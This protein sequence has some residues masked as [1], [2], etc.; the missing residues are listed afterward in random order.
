V[1]IESSIFIHVT[2]VYQSTVMHAH[3][4]SNGETCDGQVLSLNSSAVLVLFWG[5]PLE[6]ARWFPVGE[7]ARRM[8]PPKRHAASLRRTL[9]CRSDM[10]VSVATSSSL[11]GDLCS[12]HIEEFCSEGW[13]RHIRTQHLREFR[14]R[15]PD[16]VEESGG[17]SSVP[18]VIAQS[19]GTEL[20]VCPNP[21]VLIWPAGKATF[22]TCSAAITRLASSR[23]ELSSKQGATSM[24]ALKEAQLAVLQAEVAN[25][26]GECPSPEQFLW[27]PDDE[28]WP[29]C[30]RWI[31]RKCGRGSSCD[32]PKL[33]PWSA[34][35]A[36]RDFGDAQNWCAARGKCPPTLHGRW[37]PGAFFYTECGLR[38]ATWCRNKGLPDDCF[39]AL[40]SNKSKM[41]SADGSIVESRLWRVQAQKWAHERVGACPDPETEYRWDLPVE[42]L[43]QQHHE[44]L[45]E[46]NQTDHRGVEKGK[47]DT[48]TQ[49][50]NID[51]EQAFLGQDK[52]RNQRERQKH[53][54]SATTSTSASATPKAP[55]PPSM[56]PS[57]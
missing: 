54:Q 5:D 47:W 44:K 16:K 10:S 29:E 28:L 17:V 49:Q 24:S 1:F 35:Q 34:P 37:R 38:L 57:I 4:S 48:T 21:A 45:S 23:A 7:L 26:S 13:K 36:Q 43:H 40:S 41:A 2:S 19:L 46:S 39:R 42:N 3:K 20:G 15:F 27:T 33:L 14:C 50:R 6:A 11:P 8:A 55:V 31:R 12:R 56:P 25:I 53:E 51:E 22:R 52:Q 32:V 18:W 9:R 30:E